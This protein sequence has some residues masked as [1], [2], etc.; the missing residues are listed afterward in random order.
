MRLN[1]NPR[2]REDVDDKTDFSC[3]DVSTCVCHV[4]ELL[5]SVLSGPA[6]EDRR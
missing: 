5:T 4:V 2:A 6:A 3:V 1:V